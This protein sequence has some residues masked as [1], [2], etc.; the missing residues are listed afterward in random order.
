MLDTPWCGYLLPQGAVHLVDSG[1]VAPGRIRHSAKCKKSQTQF[2]EE[3]RQRG[4]EGFT[5]K[6]KK[7]ADMG[8]V[9]L[10][11]N[12]CEEDP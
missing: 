9:D 5:Y 8:L 3:V 1:M 4:S 2:L 11:W 6:E 12:V 7:I 10:I